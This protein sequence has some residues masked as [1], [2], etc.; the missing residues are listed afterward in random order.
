[1]QIELNSVWRLDNVDGVEDGL[2][3]VLAFYPDEQ[4]LVIFKLFDGSTLQKPTAI[5][6]SLFT[7][8][9]RAHV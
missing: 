2:Y 3:R 7:Q 5:D 9:G 6:L 4:L 1:M 8:I